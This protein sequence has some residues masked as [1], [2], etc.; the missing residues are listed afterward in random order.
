LKFFRYERGHDGH[1]SDTE[2]LILKLNYYGQ[3][4]LLMVFNDLKIVYERYEAQ[5]P[6]P[7]SGKPYTSAEF[8]NFPSLVPETT[9][10]KQPRDQ[11]LDSVKV[12]VWCRQDTVEFTIRGSEE[13]KYELVE[14]DFEDAEKLEKRFLNYRARIQT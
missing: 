1:L 7:E 8:S 2:K 3:D 10:I 13:N 14:S 4:D 6:Q 12:R 5:P 11:V 9:W